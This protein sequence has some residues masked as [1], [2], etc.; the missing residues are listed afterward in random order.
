M[1]PT[2]KAL[3]E[4]NG[5]RCMICG[6]ITPYRLLNWHHI[7]PKSV[8]K[9]LSEPIDDSYENAALLCLNCHAL[10]HAFDYCSDEYQ[11]YM[12]IIRQNKK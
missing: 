5:Y 3:I 6:K 1:H 11:Q 2:K 12:D 10:V 9:A 8:C 7:K 4:R